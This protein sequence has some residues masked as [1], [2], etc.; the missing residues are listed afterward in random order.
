MERTAEQTLRGA[1][2]LAASERSEAVTQE[3]LSAAF[4]PVRRSVQ[5]AVRVSKGAT[6]PR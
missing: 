4:S 5:D 1:A 3:M 2:C 6:P